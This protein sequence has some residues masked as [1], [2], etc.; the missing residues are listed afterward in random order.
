MRKTGVA[1]LKASLSEYLATVKS[2][3]EV[4]ITEHGRPI[5]RIVPV[6]ASGPSVSGLDELVRAGLLRRP[7]ARLDKAFWRL[8]RPRDPKAAARAA[9][10]A[11]R[12][13]GR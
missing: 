2:G 9:L 5:A 11:E 1:K 13:T 7:E 4:L 10:S 3:D 12:E 6:T 8:A